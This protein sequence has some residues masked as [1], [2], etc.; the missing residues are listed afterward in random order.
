MNSFLKV[1]LIL[2]NTHSI[3]STILETADHQQVLEGNINLA[4]YT[5]F[6]PLYWRQQE[7]NSFLK[8]I[9]ILLNTHSIPST[10][11]ETADHQQVLEGNINLAEYTQ[12]SLH[13]TGGSKR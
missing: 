5:V 11:L 10:I 1:I 6:P 13:C 12:C 8:V 3:P 4:E 2:L 7:M 9:L